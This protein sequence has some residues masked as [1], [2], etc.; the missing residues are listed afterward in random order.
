MSGAAQAQALAQN[1]EL[2]TTLGGQKADAA[3]SQADLQ[4]ALA[5]EALGIK[6]EARISSAERQ[7]AARAAAD[8]QARQNRIRIAEL[9]LQRAYDVEG[10]Q[11]EDI[12]SQQAR[13]D[14]A[15]RL[16]TQTQ[17]DFANKLMGMSPAD[18]RAFLGGSATTT[19]KPNWFGTRFQG[20]TT[21]AIKGLT[22][23]EGLPITVGSANRALDAL[24]A[25]LT[26]PDATGPDA[27]TYWANFYNKIGPDAIKVYVLAGR[28]TGM[29]EIIPQLFG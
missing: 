1:L 17:I 16:R 27:Y 2:G 11:R 23:Q 4:A 24:D 3:I 22:S 25:A 20:Q 19:P 12:K 29:S 15:D 9:A 14:Y 10:M 18:R 26:S 5:R 6:S 21:S 13:A 8:E 7:A 28:P